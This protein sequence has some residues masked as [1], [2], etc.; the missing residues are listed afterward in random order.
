MYLL[1]KHIFYLAICIGFSSCSLLKEKTD[2]DNEFKAILA[3]PITPE[4]S[5]ELIGEVGS[6]WLYGEGLGETALTVGSAVVFPP[7]AV[8]VLGNGILSISGYEPILIS[9]AL[10]EE[11]RDAWNHAYSSIVS[12]PGKV[13]SAI[14]GREFRNKD[15]AKEKIKDVL[16]KGDA[17]SFEDDL[18]EEPYGKD[19]SSR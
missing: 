15:V 5:E 19:R 10:P 3:K 9:D 17:K 4:K 12:S 7:Y 16:S 2:E 14:A 18:K 6:N 8:Y 11:E 13:T 1:I